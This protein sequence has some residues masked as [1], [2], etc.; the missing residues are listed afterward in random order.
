MF[1]ARPLPVCPICPQGSQV[2]KVGTMMALSRGCSWLPAG[3]GAD[4]YELMLMEMLQSG[5]SPLYAHT[6]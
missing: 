4:R 1:Q 6:W 3:M 2:L 5:D